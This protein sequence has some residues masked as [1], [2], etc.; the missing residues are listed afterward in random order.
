MFKFIDKKYYESLCKENNE[1]KIKLDVLSEDNQN[2]RNVN[3][4]YIKQYNDAK[5]IIRLL[6]NSI[7]GKSQI[8]EVCPTCNNPLF[9]NENLHIAT[10]TNCNS[11]IR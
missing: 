6:N 11:I 4:F 10:C 8:P 9:Y 3:D 2:L 7:P 5:T 1:F